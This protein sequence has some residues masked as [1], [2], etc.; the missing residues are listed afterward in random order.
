[1]NIDKEEAKKVK[2]V[3]KE[4]KA[5]K[6]GRKGRIVAQIFVCFLLTVAFVASAAGGA[7]AAYYKA[8]TN[9]ITTDTKTAL[10]NE[11]TAVPEFLNLIDIE[12]TIVTADAMS[13][14]KKI[15]SKIIEKKADYTI[16]VK[17]NQPTLLHDIAD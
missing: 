8:A 17:E 14:Q 4:K 13:C 10:K 11:I 9:T 16:A 6:R 3:K 2:K 1:M 5:R 12:G 7:V 15:V